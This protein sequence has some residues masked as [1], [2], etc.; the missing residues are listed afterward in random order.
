MK[1]F[2]VTPAMGKR[3]I[4]KAMVVHPDVQSALKS[5]T[6]VIVAGTTN[7]Y[8][9]QEILQATGHGGFETTGFRR[10]I[11]LPPTGA[12]VPKVDFPGDVILVKGVWQRGKEIFDVVD[13]LQAGD[14][15]L[16]GANALDLASSQAGVLI[17]HPMG[18]TI[19][20]AIPA[21][22]GRRVK[23]IVP[24][25]L[26][27]RIGS[28]CGSQSALAEAAN[29]L[30]SPDAEGPRLMPVPGAVF[31]ELDAAALLTGACAHLVAAGGVC[32]AEG[33]VWLAIKG[34]AQQEQAA[35]ELFKSL[36]AEGP[37]KP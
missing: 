33:S 37:Y 25:G 5:G 6:L 34:T 28:G 13:H 35:V 23:L 7:G 29:L 15:I 20:A 22:I 16:K 2:V 10:G 14:V 8:V 31:T 24:I 19:G 1:Q 3:L 12:S 9:A 4:A 21:V 27:K 30:N 32:G 17:G 18:G 11:T 36:A 26:E